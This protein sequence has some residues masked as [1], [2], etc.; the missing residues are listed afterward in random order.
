MSLI[1]MILL[2]SPGN[3]IIKISDKILNWYSWV[4][5]LSSL[6]E[7]IFYISFFNILIANLISMIFKFRDYVGHK[8]KE[9]WHVATPF[10]S[11]NICL[12]YNFAVCYIPDSKHLRLRQLSVLWHAPVTVNKPVWQCVLF[13][14]IL[15]FAAWHAL[16]FKLCLDQ[17]YSVRLIHVDKFL[18]IFMGQPVLYSATYTIF[19]LVN[20]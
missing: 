13:S 2:D 4:C 1:P 9:L 18:S 16:Y 3:R 20:V 5:W 12:G 6:V 7:L 17:L 10:I 8:Y 19:W 15:Y 14:I 11:Q